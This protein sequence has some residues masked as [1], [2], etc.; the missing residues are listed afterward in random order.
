[1]AIR[2][3][4]DVF[5][6]SDEDL[7][8]YRRAV[9]AMQERRIDDP[10][11]WRYQAAMHEYIPGQDPL[12]SSADKLPSK[13]DQDRFWTRCQHSSWFFLPW[14]RMYLHHFEKI[15]AAEIERQGGPPNWALP[16]WNYSDP[17]AQLLP[18]AFRKQ[19]GPNAL[20]VAAR[21]PDCNAGRSFF[22]SRDVN[23]SCLKQPDFNSPPQGGSSSFGGP[24]TKF[25]HGQGPI[26]DLE[27]TPHGSMHVAIGG[28]GWMSAFNTAALDPIFWLHHANIDRLWEVWL[29]DTTHKNP[30]GNDWLTSVPFEFHDLNGQ[31]VSMTPSQVIDTRAAPL[32]YEY[33]DTPALPAVAAGVKMAVKKAMAAKPQMVGAT[34]ESF[35]VEDTTHAEFTVRAPPALAAGA[36]RK[37]RRYFLNIENLTATDRAGAYDVYLNV[38]KGD[39]PKNHD[40]LFVGRMPLF[41]LVEA[42]RDEGEHAGSGLHYVLDITDFVT[43]LGRA[44]D[45][46]KVRVSFVPARARARSQVRVGRVSVYFT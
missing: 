42:S 33:D 20:Y 41:G 15:V 26:G 2:V 29:R 37:A 25:N 31:V 43:R 5:K 45:W 34:A 11:S 9:A 23:L 32:L 46:K 38:P 16:Y 35:N 40:E 18:P 28:D 22:Q 44:W 27:G 4:R 19:N 7:N 14:H 36:R 8:W 24:I 1:M 17:N 6:L 12:A 3:R 39:D 21:D 10:L 30:V 13:A